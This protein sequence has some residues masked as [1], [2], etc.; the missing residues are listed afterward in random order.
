MSRALLKKILRFGLVG[1]FVTGLVYLVFKAMLALGIHHLVAATI[2]WA[3][4]VGI[5]YVL[6]R[7]FTFGVTHRA[8]PKEFGAFVGGYLLQLGL[9]LTTYWVLMDLI[10]LSADLA[11]V[12]NLFITST[13]SF[14]FMKLVVFRGRTAAA[15]V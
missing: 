10:G 5:S 14:V 8:E 13:F 15:H 12:A 2:G 6:N 9:G 1:G 11:F 4:G 3:A 7:S